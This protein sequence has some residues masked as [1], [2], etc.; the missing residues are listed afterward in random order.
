MLPGKKHKVLN[1]FPEAYGLS[2]NKSVDICT[3]DTKAKVRKIAG[4]LAW[5]EAVALNCTVSV[6]LTR[7]FKKKSNNQFHLGKSLI[8]LE[9]LLISLDLNS[10]NTHCVK[11]SPWSSHRGAVVN[12]S[13]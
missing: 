10:L 11:N 9:R 2:W 12:E 7:Q 4:T 5:I 1:N 6:F 3:G 13:N 8:N